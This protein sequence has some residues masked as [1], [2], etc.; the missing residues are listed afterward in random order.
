MDANPAELTQDAP[1]GR[2]PTL[3]ELLVKHREWMTEGRRL[4][5]AQQRGPASESPEAKA[6]SVTPRP[7][8]TAEP[9]A[10]I[11]PTSSVPAPAAAESHGVDAVVPPPEPKPARGPRRRPRTWREDRRAAA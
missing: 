2:K 7:P 3:D 8:E 5:G 6:P 4:N 10:I 11:P 9:A 1:A